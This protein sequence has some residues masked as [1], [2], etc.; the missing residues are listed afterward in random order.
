LSSRDLT[1]LTDVVLITC[2]IRRGAGD[3]VARA[4]QEAGARGAVMQLGRGPG[5]QDRLGVAG[6]FPDTEKEIVHVLAATEQAQQVFE[7]MFAAGGL[8]TPGA[9]FIYATPLEKVAACLPPDAVPKG[10]G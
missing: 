1:V 6:L 9:G 3:D 10:D 8:D 2:V 4:A 7:R 5:V